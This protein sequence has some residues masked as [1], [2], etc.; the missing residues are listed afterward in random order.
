MI[1]RAAATRPRAGR[2]VLIALAL[3][4]GTGLLAG[5]SSL[6]FLTPPPAEMQG[7]AAAASA[8]INSDRA[9][10]R[11]DVQA[12]DALRGMLQNYLDLARFQD[13]PATEGINAAELERLVRAAPAQA[14]GLLETEGYFNADVKVTREDGPNGLPLLRVV[15]NPGPRTTV[16]SFRIDAKFDAA[17]EA[18]GRKA[19]EQLRSQWP[20]QP[21]QPFRQSTWNDAKSVALARLR[22][23]GYASAS[24]LNTSAVVDAANNS[25]KLEL[26]AD[27]GP[28]YQLGEIR[29]EG[30]ERYGADSVRQLATFRPGEPYTE[31]S[32]LDFQERLQKVGLFEGASVELVPDLESHAAAPVLVRV[33][34]L[35]LQQATVGIGYSANVGPRLSLEH[36]H[37]R[38]FHFAG[39]DWVAKNKFE[40]GPSL[41]S[42]EG[43]LTTHPLDD[44]YRNVI[45]GTASQ[46]RTDDQTLTSWSARVGRT[47]DSPRFERLY[48]AEL[49]HA[50]LDG[51]LLTSSADAATINYHWVRRDLDNVL[52]PTRGNTLALQSALGYGRGTQSTLGEPTIEE[53][54]PFVRL[55][56]RFT[57]YR[58][59]GKD[60][61]ATTRVEAGQVFTKAVIGVPDTLLFRAGGDDSVRGY[62]YRTLGPV[63][64]DVVTSGRTL[65]TGSLEVARPISPKYPAFWWAAFIDAGNA[66][67][68]W[69]DLHP[70]VG[71]G[72]GL[73]WRS[74]VGPLR[75][76]L[77]Y[78]QEVRQF[79]VHFS[80]GIAF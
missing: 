49:S 78:G 74:P 22:S 70:V 24:W 30:L 71:Y 32:L 75:V 73:R 62:G 38:L 1:E 77:A 4:I 17:D 15:V 55:Y 79:R 20:L 6:S 16:T 45:S 3:L 57:W 56:G 60:W 59:L 36:Y 61:Y 52:L 5:C 54:G 58:P 34:E 68:R 27:S 41:K 66:A 25:V 37:R 7:P 42:W 26:D 65:L 11:I 23:D 14:R 46:L 43:G 44:L 12:P 51:T 28:L 80:V 47:Q 67:D 48:F 31:K 8:P 13:A 50:R 72:V 19:L 40:L 69:Q 2:G 39:S 35:P 18:A 9:E 64:S 76:D 33:K 53:R 63:V 29:I 21:G 10:Y